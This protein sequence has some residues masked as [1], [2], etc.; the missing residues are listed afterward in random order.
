VDNITHTLTALALSQAGLNRKTRFATLALVVG[1][2]LPDVDA[3]WAYGGGATYLKYHRGITHSFVGVTVLAALLAGVIY[4]VGRRTAPTRKAP[5]LDGRWLLSLCWIATAGHLLMDFTNAYGVR[6]LLPFSAR[7]YAWDIMFIL[8]PLLLV[9]LAL[10]LGVPAILRLASDEVG[11][12]RPTYRRGAIFSLTCLVLLWGLRD[13]AHR[14]VL[15]QLDSHTYGQENPTRLGAFPSPANPFAW[16]AVVETESS[17]HM[18]QA[19]ALDSDVDANNT[20]VFHRSQPSPALNAALK[21]RTGAIFA[22]FAQFLW[23]EV[24]ESE[25]GSEVLLHDLR[26]F[27]R[28]SPNHGF[29]ARIELDRDLRVRSQSFSFTA[30]PRR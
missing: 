16:M 25:D 13:L 28:S 24:Y 8:D 26:F 23:A 22:D 19:N 6:P 21:T 10:G 4:F 3:A 17:Y 18:L 1:S 30:G 5:P 20:E 27:S 9:L 2:N 29:V 12:R 14:R 15:G 7:W 11:A